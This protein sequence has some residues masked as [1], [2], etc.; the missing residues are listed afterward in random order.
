[1]GNKRASRL[2]AWTARLASEPSRARSAN[3]TA[4]GCPSLALGMA[5]T[6]AAA[7]AE[8][9]AD[10]A[11]AWDEAPRT[12][13]PPPEWQGTAG[14]SDQAAATICATPM[15]LQLRRALVLSWRTKLGGKRRM[16]AEVRAPLLS[17]AK[18]AG[19]EKERVAM[20]S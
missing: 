6:S 19:D 2:P 5:P 15:L 16:V 7:A 14:R 8:V 20:G 11:A 10:A 4:D 17:P 3:A 1:M 9:A 13:L 12:R 18:D